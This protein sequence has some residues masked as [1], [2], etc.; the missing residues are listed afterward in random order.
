[1]LHGGP[2]NDVIYGGNTKTDN[3]TNGANT[4]EL[5]YKYLYGDEGDDSLFL[6][7]FA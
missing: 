1:M 2:G 6:S 3:R 7:D 4:N 5:D